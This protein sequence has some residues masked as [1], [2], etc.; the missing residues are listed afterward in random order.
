MNRSSLLPFL[1]ITGSLSLTTLA[2]AALIGYWDFN[3]GT[4]TSVAN[5]ANASFNG[6]VAGGAAWVPGPLGFGS[7][8]SFDGVDDQVNTSFSAVTG[9]AARTVAA[10]IKYP[11]QPG[12][13]PNEFDAIVSY[14]NNTT[15]N[16]W[17]F[18]VSDTGAITPY[19]L[20]L[21]AS[22][23]GVNAPTLLNDDAWHHVAVVQSGGTLG[24]VSLYVDGALQSVAYNGGGAALA[25]NTVTGA[26]T[27]TIGGSLHS[28]AYNFLGS[29]DEVRMY[30]EAL[31]QSQ[32]Q[33]LMVPEPSASLLSLAAVTLLTRRRR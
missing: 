11:N 1:A 12:S 8:L 7:A 26:N 24:T 19:Q 31:T 18:R 17:T 27:L 32:V 21:E 2:P 23:G 25:I 4:G 3:E 5:S 30:D 15:S 6:T 10:W 29:I 20:R 33:A 9:S 13:S 14:G 22:G 16:R 28:A